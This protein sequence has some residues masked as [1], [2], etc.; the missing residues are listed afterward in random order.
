MSDPEK[1]RLFEGSKVFIALR[2]KIFGIENE[3]VTLEYLGSFVE[4]NY[5]LARCTEWQWQLNLP[6]TVEVNG[7][8]NWFNSNNDVPRYSDVAL[9]G[10]KGNQELTFSKNWHITLDQDNKPVK[11]R[12]FDKDEDSFRYDVC[13]ELWVGYKDFEGNAKWIPYEGKSNTGGTEPVLWQT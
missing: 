7:Y 6:V 2:P 4:W 12:Q 11:A 9:I 5:L 3:H 1:L 13:N 8:A 10:F